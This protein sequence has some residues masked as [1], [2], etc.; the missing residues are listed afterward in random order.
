MYES[1][2]STKICQISVRY[3][4]DLSTLYT[5]ILIVNLDWKKKSN[6]IQQQKM[7]NADTHIV[8]GREQYTHCNKKWNEILTK[9]D[10]IRILHGL[11]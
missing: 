4:L 9:T 1:D 8:F 10:L 3:N 2:V 5:S 6:Y 11:K 7:A